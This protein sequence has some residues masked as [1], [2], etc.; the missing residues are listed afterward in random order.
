VPFDR[1]EQK[2]TLAETVDW[3]ARC[4]AL[5]ADVEAKAR[6]LL[7]DT[8]GCLLAGLRHPEVR[9][10]GRG[11]CATFPGEVAWPGSDIRLGPA[12]SAALG[13][14]AA[15]WDEACEGNAS[16]HGRP[17]LPVV[18]ALLALVAD[19]ETTVAD[20]LLALATGYEIGTRAGEAWRIPAGLHVDG[21]WHSLGVAAAVARLISGPE[22]IQPA[23]E[24]AA[25]QIPAS[26]YLPIAAG[27]VV[28]NTYVSHAVLLGMLSAAAADAKLDMPRGALEEG[29][30]H[31][32]RAT[33]GA[34][35]S[36]PGAWTIRDGYLKPFA[37]VRHTH[38]GVAAALRIRRQ[39]DFSPDKVRR[40]TLAIYEEAA[41]YC[42]NRAPRTAIQAQFS[43]SYAVA[44]AL[45]LGDLGPEAYA[46]VGSDTVIARLEPLVVVEVDANRV[47]RGAKLTVD[48]GTGVLSEEV[49]GVAGDPGRAMSDAEVVDKFR[50]YA[51]P[52]LGSRQVE[53]VTA[54][55]LQGD[56]RQPARTCFAV[57][58]CAR[59]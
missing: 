53:A 13:A 58:G 25:C 11:L 26:L 20:L 30:R 50:R 8:F 29:R 47:G 18:P 52:A 3:L 38:Y 49:D 2:S 33:E 39:P 32:L 23:I 35:V 51:G 42:G 59:S 6:R 4:E 1:V 40:I 10:L 54:F 15:C 17:G 56:R 9:Q 36:P 41:R 24:T 45:L 16:A 48:I 12:G 46:S 19:R 37:G 27:S 14:A 28:R 57:A 22:A 44:A 43:L 55:I 31:V 21:S 5:P 34:H 7:L